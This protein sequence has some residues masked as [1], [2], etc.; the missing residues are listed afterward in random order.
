MT[1]DFTESQVEAVSDEAVDDL[2]KAWFT[3]PEGEVI[4][5][6]QEGF[7]IRMRQ[8]LTAFKATPEWQ[9]LDQQMERVRELAREVKRLNEL[10]MDFRPELDEILRAA[11]R[12]RIGSGLMRQL[13]AGR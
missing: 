12:E 13:G 7:R 1:P 8:V 9:A 11:R 6:P 2:I 10:G 4:L 3:K 5:D